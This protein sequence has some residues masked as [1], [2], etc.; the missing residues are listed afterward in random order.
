MLRLAQSSLAAVAML[1]FC[2]LLSNCGGG[3]GGGQNGLPN[4]S[5]TVTPSFPSIAIGATEQ[6][7]VATVDPTTGNPMTVSGITFSWSSS[8]TSVATI[9]SSTGLATAVGVGTATIT[10]SAINAVGNGVLN[11]IATLKVSNP[12]AAATVSLPLGALTVPYV[13]TGLTGSGG[14]TGGAGPLAYSLVSG[15]SL[16]AGLTLAS[17]GSISG[18]PTSAGVSPAFTVQAVDTETPP[19][20][21]QATF[22]MTIVDPANPCALLSNTNP[23]VLSGHYALYLQGFQAGTTN[24]MPVA[25]AGSFA[26]NGAGAITGGEVDINVA[27]GPQHLTVNGGSYSV[28]SSGPGC[29][30]LKYT[31]GTSNT[32][33]FALSQVLNASNVATHGRI[34]EFD[35]YQG[36]S[37]GTANNFTSGLLLL[38][39]PAEFS[40][41]SLAARFAFGQDGFDMAGK[42]VAIG[43]SFNFNNANGNLTSFAE[44]FDDGGTISTTTG[45][46]GAASSTATTSTTGRETVTLT[47]GSVL[48]LAAYIVNANEMFLISID[49]LSATVPIYSGRAIVTASSYT[50]GSFSGNYIYRAE[51]VDYQ[52]DGVACAASAPCALTDTAVVNANSS[53]GAYSGTLYQLQNG[54][55]ATNTIANTTYTVNASTG[56]VQL[57]SSGGGNLP[58]FYLATP[59]TSG[60]DQTESFSAF[61]VGSGAV[62]NSSSGDPTALSGFLET[63]PNGPYSLNSPPSYVFASEDP[64]Q[65]DTGSV[66][67]TGSFSSES[68]SILRDTS[69]PNGVAINTMTNSFSFTPATNGTLSGINNTSGGSF[70]GVTNSTAA[71]PGKALFMPPNTLAGIRLLEP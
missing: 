49:P 40:T 67:G 14:I 10:V 68:I 45:A 29:L 8:S 16:P 64:G 34:I 65:L 69:G 33:H 26:A 48:H 12:L 58:V 1:T 23:Q 27:A 66:V 28:A 25:F 47:L 18:T 15:T 52:G 22:T 42:H 5:M 53:S 2:L 19:I 55:T 35:A 9:N 43:G 17:N 51:G 31:N 36:A 61:L 71:S 70:V 6:F 7:T 44:D 20:T 32:F 13:S 38:Q 4:F 39:N 50:T 30:Q 37:G 11:Q 59:V 63:Q 57:A 56:R 41:S 54:V 21:K 24:G 60:T 3:N 62:M 46:T